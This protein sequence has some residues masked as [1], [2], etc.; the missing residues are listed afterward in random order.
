MDYKV[1]ESSSIHSHVHMHRKTNLLGFLPPEAHLG[2]GQV[3]SSGVQTGEPGELL[4]RKRTLLRNKICLDLGVRQ[5]D[6]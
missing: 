5:W 1:F 3:P 6:F 4:S 2:K